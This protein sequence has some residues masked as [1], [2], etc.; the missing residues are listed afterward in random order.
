MLSRDKLNHVVN[1]LNLNNEYD[2]GIGN[3]YN[4]LTAI[5]EEDNNTFLKIIL[6]LSNK[7]SDLSL[8]DNVFTAIKHNPELEEDILDSFSDNQFIAKTKLVNNLEKLKILN[9]DTEVVIFGCW[10]GSVL[11]PLLHDKV[12]KI[13]AIDINDTV[14][15]IGQNRLF[16]KYNK[17][18]WITG[19][20]FEKY[21][22]MFDTTDIFINTSCEN[23]KP[24]YLW[25]PIGP[26]S[27]W[28]DNKFVPDWLAH[29]CYKIPWWTRVKPTAHFAFT[30]HNMF[31][32]H[33]SY[34]CVNSIEEFKGQL[35]P[36]AEVLIEDEI[37]DERGTRYLLIGKL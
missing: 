26:R 17:V 7:D 12:K 23:M 30:S 2:I 33:D 3:V 36:E 13:T 27:I 20:V 37:K 6:K 35:P 22:D 21:R 11:I 4:I 9:K 19:D 25:G 15:T 10:Y 24:M 14:I 32:I 18:D 29:K 16:E 8:L 34:N 31:D 1:I 5:K 28:K